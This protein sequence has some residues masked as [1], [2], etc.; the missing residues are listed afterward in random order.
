MT[1][2]PAF[3]TQYEFLRSSD[4]VLVTLSAPTGEIVDGQMQVAEVQ[5]VALTL[6]RFLEM[7]QLMGRIAQ[8]I[9]NDAKASAATREKAGLERR[10]IDE[11]Q[12]DAEPHKRADW[13]VRH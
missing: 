5:K 4:Y 1:S 10:S 11:D 3:I 6:P 13:I 7:A 9:Q 8:N 2:M 12:E